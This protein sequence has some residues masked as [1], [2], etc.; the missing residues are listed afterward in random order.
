MANTIERA[1]ILT[2][3]CEIRSS[4]VSMPSEERSNECICNDIAKQPDAFSL[5][6]S[7]AK[8]LE[9]MEKETIMKALESSFWIQRDAAK[10][11][12]ISPRGLNYKI[13]KYGIRHHRWK[14]FK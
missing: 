11:L 2:E 5:R 12:G 6:K 8:S 4:H 3:E 14:K 13:K 9:E 10:K 7:P 1:V